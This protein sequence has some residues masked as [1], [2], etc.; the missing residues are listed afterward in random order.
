M[1]V[2]IPADLPAG[3]YL[4]MGMI[5]PATTFFYISITVQA[6]DIQPPDV[7]TGGSAA[8]GSAVGVG[9][10]VLLIALSLS[11]GARRWATTR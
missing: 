6:E 3:D 11:L 9:V 4:I 10:S 7:H 5:Q 2:Q 1:E 8:N